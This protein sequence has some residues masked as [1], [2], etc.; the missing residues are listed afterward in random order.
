MQVSVEQLE[1]LERRL[2]VQVPAE[3]IDPEVANR[4][5]SMASNVRLHGFRPGKVPFKMVRRMYGDQ[6]RREVLEEVLQ[7]SYRDAIQQ[8]KL[9]PVSPPR[10]ESKQL[11]EG[12]ALEY[13]ATFEVLPEFEVVGIE[14]LQVERPVAAITEADVDAMIEKLRRQRL[15][16]HP[17]DRPAQPGD[18]LSI[19]SDSSSDGA[20]LPQDKQQNVALVLAEGQSRPEFQEKLLGLQAGAET[21]FDITYPA[22]DPAKDPASKTVH[23]HIK[24]NRVEEPVLPAIDEEFIRSFGISTGALEP[25]RQS[26]RESMER[27]LKERTNT[28]VKRQLMDQL[29]AAN[30]IPLPQAMVKAQ[31]TSMARQLGFPDDEDE[32]TLHLKNQLFEPEARR[33]IAF[34]LILSRL[35]EAN[36][37]KVD[38]AHVRGHLDTLAAGY[39]EAAAV[40]Q[41][42]ERTPA[43]MDS[44]RAVVLEEQV[45][46]WLLERA[47][48]TEKPNHFKEIMDP[49]TT[50][51]A[52][53][54]ATTAVQQASSDDHA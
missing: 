51:A 2:T 45:V 48:L 23:Y 52:A 6:V 14:T 47:R 37:I 31:M 9:R 18:R 33:R 49:G 29:L 42:Y 7:N 32:K 53:G 12:Q 16:W 50:A 30:P 25:L 19:D 41:Y 1:G 35:A 43:A 36:G 54:V 24:V 20:E 10:I 8:E 26:I 38:E 21:E 5:K 13:S 44:I 15:A 22:A 46:N 3:N 17:V 28:M 11:K 34:G 4:L 27:E 40:I 39:E